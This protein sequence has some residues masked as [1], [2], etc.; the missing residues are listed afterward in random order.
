MSKNNGKG[1]GRGGEVGGETYF[2]K[3]KKKNI[4]IK[5]KIIDN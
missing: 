3:K 2:L 1:T 5:N 4:R